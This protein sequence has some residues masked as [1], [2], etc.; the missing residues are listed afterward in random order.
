MNMERVEKLLFM[1]HLV[2]HQPVIHFGLFQMWPCLEKTSPGQG[3][4]LDLPQ[5]SHLSR[6]P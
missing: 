2:L 3:E 5:S 1:D 4:T 6:P